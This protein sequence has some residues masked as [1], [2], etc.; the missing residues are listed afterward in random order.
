[1]TREYRLLLQIS[2]AGRASAHLVYLVGRSPLEVPL[3]WW[4]DLE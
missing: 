3:E 4:I 2:R 1:M